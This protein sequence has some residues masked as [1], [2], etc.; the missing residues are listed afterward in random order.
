MVDKR[1]KKIVRW[2]ITADGEIHIK[3]PARYPQGDLPRLLK[4]IEKKYR[5]TERKRQG[6][7]D[8]DLKQRADRLIRDAFGKPIPY[9]SIR[10][11][12]NMQNRLGSCT[13]GG[14]T[15][16]HIRLSDRMKGWPDWVVDY[17]IVHELAHRLH[18]DHSPAF[19]ADVR[20]AYTR[21]DEARAWVKGYFFA[22]GEEAHSED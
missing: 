5:R 1:L 22:L 16:G 17:V 2:Q 15:D 3:V 10:W 18:P 13:N 14:A 8:E 4:Q 12:G 19:W 9:A 20:A 6:R 11:V 7:T 21:T